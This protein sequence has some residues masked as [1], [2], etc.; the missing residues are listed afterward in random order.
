M[1]M[2]FFLCSL[3]F[4]DI[5]NFM[6]FPKILS[7]L[8]KFTIEKKTQ[9]YCLKT[10]KKF[11]KILYNVGIWCVPKFIDKLKCEYE[12]KKMEDQG[13]EARSMAHNTLGVEGHARASKWD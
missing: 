4:F 11:P 13:V 12:M 6:N 7:I 8:I 9:F 3:K 2:D 5:E 1:A 10:T